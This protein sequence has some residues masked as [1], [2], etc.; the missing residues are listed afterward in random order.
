MK[1]LA[2]CAS[3]GDVAITGSTLAL[4]PQVPSNYWHCS[5]ICPSCDRPRYIMV[6]RAIA[7]L[8]VANGAWVLHE[9]LPAPEA[10]LADLLAFRCALDAADSVHEMFGEVL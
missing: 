8:L 5:F 6:V 3:C 1:L 7:L 2:T 10:D 9:S 4:C